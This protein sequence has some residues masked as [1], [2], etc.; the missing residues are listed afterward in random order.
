MLVRRSKRMMSGGPALALLIPLEHGEIGDPEE[1]E[2]LARIAALLESTMSLSIFL[3]QRQT[4]QARGRINSVVMLLDLRLH[5][6]LG[7]V[8]SRLAVSGNYHDQ[9][10]SVS[11]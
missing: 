8:L 10:V 11:G 6:A 3:S 4:Q 7:F 9:V 1:A 2:V 5:P